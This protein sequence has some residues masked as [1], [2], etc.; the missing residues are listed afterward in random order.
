MK[1]LAY[2][3]LLTT[4]TAFSQSPWTQKKGETYL[5]LSFT[6]IPT[7]S[8]L[9]GNPDFT[10]ERE[11]ND[12]TLQLYAEYGISDKT[13]LIANLPF[14]F[15]AS[16]DLV[17]ASAPVALTAEESLTSLGNI[18]FGVRHNFYNKKWLISGQLTIGANSGTFDAPSGLRTGYDAWTFTPTI[19]VGRGFNDWYIQAFTGV[20]IRT[21]DYSSNF[22]LGGEV[23]YKAISW[24]WLAGFL[25]GVASF[26]NGD[27][28]IPPTNALTGLYVNDQSYAAF[29]LKL[30]GEFDDNFGA[31]FGFGGAFDGRRVA[32][33]PALTL[34]LYYKL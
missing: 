3:L 11:L 4:V 30:I 6:T 7:Y 16:K 9:F 14:K 5:Q 26:T 15:V 18:Q 25:D 21:N 24:L 28:I 17:D 22:K 19:S 34:G 27:V 2:L 23:G 8:E 12:N 1:K 33:S 29:G 31:N 10:T 32:K 20:D 13:T